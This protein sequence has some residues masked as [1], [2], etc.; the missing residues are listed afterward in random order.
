MSVL[1][2]IV[3]RIEPGTPNRFA[4]YVTR[5]GECAIPALE[6]CGYDVLGGWKWSSGPIGND[7]LLI[8]FDSEAERAEASA[9]L[10]PSSGC[11]KSADH[12]TPRS[13]RGA[14]PGNHGP[15][16]GP[17][18]GFRRAVPRARPPSRSIPPWPPTLGSSA[19]C[20]RRFGG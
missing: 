18:R 20:L 17:W 2:E 5:Y 15:A 10:I 6:R 4:D 12:S 1:V 19:G 16:L 13:R 3:H 9:S 14:G 11:R 7:L 8:R